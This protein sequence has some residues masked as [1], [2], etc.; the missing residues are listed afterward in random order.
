MN[1]VLFSPHNDD[2]TLFAFYTLLRHKPKVI[3]C[4]RSFKEAQNGGPT[5]VEREAE[6]GMAMK[7]AGCEWEQ[8][9]HSDLEPDWSKIKHDI[10][11]AV[12]QHDVVMGP[13]WENGGH[14]Q[15]NAIA[16]LIPDARLRYLTYKRG[17]G[18]TEGVEVV[19][20]VFEAELKQ[21]ALDCYRSQIRYQPTA[22]WFGPDQR[23][24]VAA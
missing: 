10:A 2:E 8:W 24:F 19:P 20:N 4:L 7:L 11:E 22:Y 5:Y 18:R 13:A 21:R 17:H 3:V 12:Q 6:T 1:A 9:P 16:G 14:E 23:E 15:H